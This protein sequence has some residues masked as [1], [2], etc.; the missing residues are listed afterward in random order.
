MQCLCTHLWYSLVTQAL[1]DRLGV[2]DGATYALRDLSLREANVDIAV[3][4]RL[5]FLWLAATKYVIAA[6]C[7]VSA[8]V[9]ETAILVPF[10]DFAA[11][12]G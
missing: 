4:T 11:Q 8:Q 3:V 12:P 5:G 10:K 1:L 6:V 7:I 9:L 2:G